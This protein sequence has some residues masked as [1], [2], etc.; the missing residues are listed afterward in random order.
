[1]HPRRIVVV[2]LL[3]AAVAC[4]RKRADPN[5][6]FADVIA[7]DEE[8]DHSGE[9]EPH[10]DRL[11]CHRMAFDEDP[12]SK[13][14]LRGIDVPYNYW[15]RTGATLISVAPT[16]EEPAQRMV[17]IGEAG[18]VLD[19]R[20]HSRLYVRLQCAFPCCLEAAEILIPDGAESVI[21]LAGN[22]SH[23]VH[24]WRLD[25]STIMPKGYVILGGGRWGARNLHEMMWADKV[26]TDRLHALQ[27]CDHAT[28]GTWIQIDSPSRIVA[29]LAELDVCF[30]HH[31]MYLDWD[32][33]LC[34]EFI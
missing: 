10:P 3:V 16:L 8:H 11:C 2:L 24:P 33:D 7:E 23:E 1:M 14:S 34:N 25:R 9:T 17:T 31:D 20:E 30:V 27:L 22:A 18:L 21:V 32:T 4:V 5:G 15:W 6:W 19:F 28:T 12:L 29:V 26:Y 13:D